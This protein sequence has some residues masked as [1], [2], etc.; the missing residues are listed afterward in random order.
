MTDSVTCAG[1]VEPAVNLVDEVSLLR[2]LQG[3]TMQKRKLGFS[4]LEVSAVAGDE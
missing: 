2:Q 4:D 1:G 3:G